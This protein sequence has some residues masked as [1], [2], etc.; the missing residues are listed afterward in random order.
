MKSFFDQRTRSTEASKIKRFLLDGKDAQ[1]NDVVF[2]GVMAMPHCA[3]NSSDHNLIPRHLVQEI[4]HPDPGVQ[5]QKLKILIVGTA[6]GGIRSSDHMSLDLSLRT[7]AGK[8]SLRAV[9][10]IVTETQESKFRLGRETL[11]V[12]GIDV[13]AQLVELASREMID[14]D[15]FEGAHCNRTEAS[16]REEIVFRLHE[17]VQE[18]VAN[19]FPEAKRGDLLRIVKKYGIWCVRVGDDPPS[20][21]KPIKTRIKPDAQPY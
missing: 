1:S 11:R 6:V 19:G 21:I 9:T 15:P 17:M 3:D 16:D 18:A 2:S 5:V 14:T 7:T 13:D 10:C 20:K 8:V 12:L 4:L